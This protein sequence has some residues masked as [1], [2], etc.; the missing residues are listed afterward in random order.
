MASYVFKRDGQQLGTAAG[1]YPFAGPVGIGAVAAPT[2]VL[3]SLALGPAALVVVGGVAAP[4]TVLGSLTLSPTAL[5]AL[6][7]AAA[8][9]VILG[10]LVLSPAAAAALAALS[11][12]GMILG[13]L[14]VAPV[15]S[16]VVGAVAHTG[17][18]IP[19]V[20]RNRWATPERAGIRQAYDVIAQGSREALV[21]LLCTRP[22]TDYPQAVTAT[23]WDMTDE[24]DVS[25]DVLAEG[26]PI[27]VSGPIITL[28]AISGLTAGRCYRVNVQFSE[29]NQTFECYFVLAGES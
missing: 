16:S 20:L 17:I 3:G 29:G 5:A 18:T 26:D 28:P 11:G 15:A 14:S 25:D 27:S 24:I 6:G 9:T 7:V 4:T 13:S 2:L 22:W 12:P 10:S 23:V 19:I 21:Y 8:P 1:L